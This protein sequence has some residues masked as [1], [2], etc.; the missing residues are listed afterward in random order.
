MNIKST[1]YYSF[2]ISIA[3]IVFITFIFCF[4]SINAIQYQMIGF[5][6]GYNATVAANIMRY[7][8]YRVSYPTNVTFYNTISTGVAV[9]LPTALAYKIFGINSITSSIVAVL[10]SVLCIFALWWLLIRCFPPKNNIRYVLSAV[11]VSLLILSDGLYMHISRNLLGEIAA[12]F[13]LLCSFIFLSYYFETKKSINVI[14]AGSM[15]AFSFLTKSSMIFFVISCFGMVLIESFISGTV[16]K[17]D[18]IRY[19]LGFMV[20]FIFLDTYKLIQLGGILSYIS[21]WKAECRNML[22]QSSG[23]DLSYSLVNKFNY[24]ESIFSGCNKYF[25]FIILLTPVIVYAIHVFAKILNKE[26]EYSDGAL[27]MSIAGV[28][29]SSLIIYFILLGGSGLVYARRHEVN[30]I[31]VRLFIAY[32][33][34]FI[35]LIVMELVKGYYQHNG[36]TIMNIVILTA[37]VC[38]ITTLNFPWSKI[39]NN[40]ISY[41]NKEKEDSYSVQLMKQFL[42]EVEELPDDS[43][44][45]C[46]GW[47][48]EPY[49]SLYLDRNMQSIY[50]VTYENIKR[51][52]NSYFIVGHVIHAVNK[53]EL[54]T[55]FDIVLVRLDETDVDYDRYSN[56]FD[57][58]DFDLFA[59]YKIE[60]I[61]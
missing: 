33:I 58:Q 18:T 47:W 44:I 37:I 42:S 60:K 21:W 4:D 28:G 57:R 26:I 10:Y 34:G 11:L 43:T 45:Y 22:S 16:A 48:Q 50:D 59:I 9:I 39:K 51:D 53:S 3:I 24:L 36:G 31:F 6:E 55:I 35:F 54:E 52:D 27:T 1:K 46:A 41:I 20:G 2:F 7:G 8:E 25:C 14:V 30:Q 61:H 23:I 12:L 38:I 17:R 13:F 49:I 29:G 32:V 40:S 5:D 19:F 15:L 56:G